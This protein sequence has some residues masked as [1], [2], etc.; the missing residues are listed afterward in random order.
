MAAVVVRRQPVA[1]L[2]ELAAYLPERDQ[3]SRR[4]AATAI[5]AACALG[6]LADLSFDGAGLGVNLALWSIAAFATVVATAS[7]TQVKPDTRRLLLA[8]LAVA[9]TATVGVRASAWLHSL[10]LGAAATMLGLA[11]ALPPGVGLKRIGFGAF[12]FALG[13]G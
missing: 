7:L 6:L 13:S 12:V 8:C 4:F 9:F 5:A 11:V 1:M 3:R 10:N 2:Q